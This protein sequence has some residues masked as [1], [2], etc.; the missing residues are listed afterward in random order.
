M[1]LASCGGDPNSPGIEYM[2]DMYRSPAME[3]YV[4]YGQDP[5]MFDDSLVHAQR[6]RMEARLPVEGTI[7]FSK[8]KAKEAFNF[9]YPYPNTP[10]GYEQ[11]GRELHSP[12]PMTEGTVA[13]GKVI[14]EK[15]C[16]HC[17]GPKGQGD[18]TVVQNGGYPPPPAYDGGQLKDLP[19]GKMF[20]SLTYGRNIAMGSHASQLNKEERWLVIQYVKFL[21]NGGKMP[22]AAASQDSTSSA[23]NSAK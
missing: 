8:D 19:E 2:P 23:P 10:E 18:G 4:D 6:D 16:I 5:Y 17:H 9:P 7:A 22:G 11:A 1:V 14:F 20:H 15:F 3:A 21:Q 13:E 12:V